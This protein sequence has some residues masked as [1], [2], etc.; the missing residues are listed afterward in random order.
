[1]RAGFAGTPE[2]AARALAALHES[3]QAIPIV[4]TQPDRRSGRGLAINSSPVKRFAA[5]HGLPTLQPARLRDPDVL[6]TLHRTELDVLVVAAYGLLLPQPVLDWPRYGCLNIHASLLP[7]WRGAAPVARAIEAGDPVTGITI[8]QMDAGLDTGPIL[9]R[10]ELSI[11]PRETAGSLH[12]RLSSV[13]ARLIVEV[14]ARLERDRSLASAPQPERGVTY[15]AKIARSDRIVFWTA[16]AD[17]I[18]RKVRALSPSPGALA[19][20]R[21]APLQ[22]VEAEPL[23]GAV[24]ETA[25]GTSAGAIL[26]VSRD[27]IDVRCAAH[28]ALRL[29]QLQPAGGRVMSAG[30][31]AAG[32]GVA[33]GGR[34]EPGIA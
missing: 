1:M 8:M 30:A 26:S 34:F 4:L 20:W 31:F 7:R 33:V 17:E 16:T 23:P 29:R 9:A 13:G 3:G 6:A 14:L 19:A 24:G 27:G 22:I 32:R 28:T 2:F 12:D 25:E 5:A 18:D 21:G 10:E 11:G 15:A